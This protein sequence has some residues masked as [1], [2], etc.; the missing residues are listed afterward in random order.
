MIRQ[1]ERQ[2][3]TRVHLALDDTLLRHDVVPNA[4]NAV[5]ARQLVDHGVGEEADEV[6]V[7]LHVLERGDRVLEDAGADVRKF[8]TKR[9]EARDSD[10]RERSVDASRRR[11]VVFVAFEL[12]VGFFGCGLRWRDV[13]Q[14]RAPS[15]TTWRSQFVRACSRWNSRES[16]V[17]SCIVIMTRSPARTC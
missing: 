10:V 15:T 5:H 14:G 16:C 7:A 2:R 8:L 6:V 13:G 12:E 1:T 3:Q 11:P 9:F 17:T 4:H